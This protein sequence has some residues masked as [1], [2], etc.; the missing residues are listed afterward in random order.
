M[1]LIIAVIWLKGRF[2]TM[3]C[4]QSLLPSFVDYI[5]TMGEFKKGKFNLKFKLCCG[6]C[7]AFNI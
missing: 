7:A 6:I 5:K 3:E 2:S 1:R 4:H